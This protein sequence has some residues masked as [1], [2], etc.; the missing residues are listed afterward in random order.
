MHI[1]ELLLHHKPPTINVK[2]ES[3]TEQGAEA[4]DEDVKERDGRHWEDFRNIDTLGR[5]YLPKVKAR[6]ATHAFSHERKCAAS[7]NGAK[8]THFRQY[9]RTHAIGDELHRMQ[10]PERSYDF[11]HTDSH[12]VGLLLFFYIRS[13]ASKRIPTTRT[14]S[15]CSVTIEMRRI[16]GF[17]SE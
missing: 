9:S 11:K 16:L 12:I 8:T 6:A 13:S 7:P 4:L 10:H 14:P 2:S 1:T 17:R 5:F 3:P 15:Q